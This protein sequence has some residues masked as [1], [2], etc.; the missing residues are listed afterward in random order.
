L[1]VDLYLKNLN[2][3]ISG[4]NRPLSRLPKTRDA[5]TAVGRLRSESVEGDEGL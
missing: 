4:S 2:L 5:G 1:D 3:F